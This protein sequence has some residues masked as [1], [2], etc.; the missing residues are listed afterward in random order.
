MLSPFGLISGF[1]NVKLYLTLFFMGILIFFIFWIIKKFSGHQSSMKENIIYFSILIGALFLIWLFILKKE[2]ITKNY[3]KLIGEVNQAVN[4]YDDICNKYKGLASNWEQEL[5]D[6]ENE[7]KRIA[8]MQEIT[9]AEKA[10]IQSI[11]EQNEENIINIKAQLINIHGEILIE[12]GK[13]KDLEKEKEK[14][15]SEIKQKEKE[16]LKEKNEQKKEKL[17]FEID[18]LRQKH[19]QIVEE[20]TNTKIKIK[21]LETAENALIKQLKI[22][23]E[24]KQNLI[25]SMNDL[26][27][28]LKKIASYIITIEDKKREIQKNIDETKTQIDKIQIEC[29]AYRNF[30]SILLVLRQNAEA[31]ERSNS[32]SLNNI[33]KL[34]FKAF[35]TVT[36]VLT[37]NM[38]FRIFQD[39]VVFD[40]DSNSQ[41]SKLS[42][43]LSKNHPIS[44]IVDSLI[45]K[46]GEDP[47]MIST[48]MLK[49]YMED[50]NKELERLEKEYKIQENKYM[51]Y[52]SQNN[53]NKIIQEIRDFKIKTIKEDNMIMGD[54]SKWI[55]EYE[56][57]IGEL[58]QK[59]DEFIEKENHLNK[60]DNLDKQKYRIEENI[61]AKE[62]EYT[63]LQQ[64]NPSYNKI[65]EKL[66]DRKN[67]KTGI[68]VPH[69]E[70]QRVNN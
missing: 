55:G 19:I 66:L 48:E 44:I 12:K 47:K 3:D 8:E 32:F 36:D 56:K 52:K 14:I 59:K 69:F 27:L 2:P 60:I 1:T 21:K 35:E 16:V 25:K 65:Q 43:N 22:V 62:I 34:F 41:I 26:N 30:K 53:N 31:W 39:K 23:E 10:K 17:Y 58:G 49:I 37:V 5:K 61:E 24:F 45:Q 6:A 68:K 20:I 64:Q 54:Y 40:K 18:R 29:E 13:L 28:E 7:L 51:E 70:I 33:S 9:E 38:R 67:K 63:E 46:K 15:E 57:L 4:K 42:I 50:I 11:I